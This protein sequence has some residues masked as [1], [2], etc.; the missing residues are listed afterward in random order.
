MIK[1]YLALLIC[2]SYLLFGNDIEIPNKVETNANYTQEIINDT[3]QNIQKTIDTIS[4]P[5]P[6]TQYKVDSKV[7]KE[8]YQ[9]LNTK[10]YKTLNDEA[11]REPI[12]TQQGLDNA[13]YKGF[14]AKIKLMQ[15][16]L[17]SNLCEAPS[18]IFKRHY[19]TQKE[20]ADFI[21]KT[22]KNNLILHKERIANNLKLSTAAS[23][24]QD[25]MYKLQAYSEKFDCGE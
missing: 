6:Y 3:N 19:N 14:L 4:K 25:S 1:T 18:E 12:E 2:V 13:Y 8:I 11:W 17:E 22:S 15:T 20:L 5:Y 24:L 16:L 23:I 7:I 9:E 10:A 21:V